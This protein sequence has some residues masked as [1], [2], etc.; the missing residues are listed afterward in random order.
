MARRAS[1][2]RG[3]NDA[4]AAATE[5]ATD[6]TVDVADLH[7]DL[8]ET[9]TR[10]PPAATTEIASVK[11]ATAEAVAA[12]AAAV[13]LDVIEE[14][15]GRGIGTVAT[16]AETI[17]VTVPARLDGIAATS[18]TTG[19]VREKTEMT[20]AAAVEENVA[21]IATMTYSHRTDVAAARPL[22]QRSASRLPI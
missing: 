19:A 20:A 13:V 12:A 11:I 3:T 4:I 15:A 1:T 7:D 14:I 17:V 5:V 16:G 2:L 9:T 22:H 8:T 18:S 21:A 10:M 6:A